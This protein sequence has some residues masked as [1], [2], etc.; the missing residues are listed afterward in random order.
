[1]KKQIKKNMKKNA[2]NI[3]GEKCIAKEVILNKETAL[4]QYIEIL[5]DLELHRQM[6]INIE[7]DVKMPKE[8]FSE[9]EIDEMN[10]KM[11]VLMMLRFGTSLM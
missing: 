6:G 3:F 5:N 10:R 11:N 2:R 1:M 4:E 8:V 7:Y 9:E